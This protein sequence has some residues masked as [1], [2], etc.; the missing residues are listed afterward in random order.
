[1]IPNR[2]GF[3]LVG[4]RSNFFGLNGLLTFSSSF[5]AI[6]NDLKAFFFQN[7]YSICCVV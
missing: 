7:T 6:L 4:C 2:I 3:S 1:M 5:F